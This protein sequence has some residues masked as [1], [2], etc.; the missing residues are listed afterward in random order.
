VAV[1]RDEPR[2]EPWASL[3]GPEGVIMGRVL[4]D[5]LGG[6]FGAPAGGR[7]GEDDD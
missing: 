1:E 2:D 3:V 7:P 5:Q 6:A 4:A